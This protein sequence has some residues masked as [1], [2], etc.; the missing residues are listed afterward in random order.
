MQHIF[1]A[2]G[3]AFA[4]RILIFGLMSLLSLSGLFTITNQP[5]LAATSSQPEETIDPVYNLNKSA[6]VQEE[7]RETAYEKTAETVENPKKGLEKIY[8]QDLKAYKKENPSQ[9]SVVEGAKNLVDKVTGK[10]ED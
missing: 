9:S 4:K 10:V 8:E 6:G 5:A 7:D 2:I 1:S 3:Q